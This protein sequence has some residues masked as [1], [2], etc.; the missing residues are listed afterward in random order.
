MTSSPS[1]TLA[2][3]VPMLRGLQDHLGKAQ[4]VISQLLAEVEPKKNETTSQEVSLKEFL[5]R[6]LSH[7]ERVKM[8]RQFEEDKRQQEK[9]EEE[10]YQQLFENMGPLSGPSGKK[11]RF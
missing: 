4:E 6:P 5:N 9:E 10:S 11:P 3:M 7:E 2:K 8:K 1:L